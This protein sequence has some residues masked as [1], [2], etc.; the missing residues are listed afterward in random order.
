MGEQTKGTMDK[1]L[2]TQKVSLIIF[3]YSKLLL[4]LIIITITIFSSMDGS[5]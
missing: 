1:I 2:Q 4:S 3:I 5:N